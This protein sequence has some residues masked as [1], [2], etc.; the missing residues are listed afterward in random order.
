[1]KAL[2]LSGGAAKGAYQIGVLR[3]WILE[4]GMDYDVFVGTSIGSLNGAYL[5]QAIKG[6]LATRL[7]RLGQIWL[8]LTSDDVYRSWC[9]GKLAALWK[10]SVYN[11]E[12]ARN[13]IREHIDKEALRSSGR[14]F[15]GVYVSWK[16]N[17][18]HVCTERDDDI[19]DGLY[20]SSSFPLFFEPGVVKGELCTDGGVRD[21]APIGQAL[22]LGATEIDAIVTADPEKAESWSPGGRSALY[23]ALRAV[24]IMATEILLNDIKLCRLKNQLPSYQK[25]QLRVLKPSKDLGDSFDFSP[26][27][28]QER[29]DLGYQDACSAP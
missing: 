24:D 20:A 25:V 10:P 23:Y 6:E 7:F 9:L 8:N 15:R 4:Q 17:K 5:A 18:V 29:M 3:R 22:D 16:T 26:A 1:M 19:H 11:T 28:S 13:I 12:G 14:L 27:R 2:V 21:I